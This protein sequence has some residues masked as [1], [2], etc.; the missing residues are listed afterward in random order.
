MSAADVII[1]SRFDWQEKFS[2]E[3]SARFPI[4]CF[5]AQRNQQS[6]PPAATNQQSISLVEVNSTVRAINNGN[7]RVAP[8]S[9]SMSI[10]NAATTNSTKWAPAADKLIGNRLNYVYSTRWRHDGINAQTTGRRVL[11]EMSHWDA[12]QSE[13]RLECSAVYQSNVQVNCAKF[14]FRA[15]SSLLDVDWKINVIYVI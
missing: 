8:K 7:Q 2:V 9:S 3:F 11:S 15:K 14:K 5:W 13:L 10:K 1:F 12:S 6:A 4:C